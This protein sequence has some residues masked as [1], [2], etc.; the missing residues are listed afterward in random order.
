[1][2]CMKKGFPEENDLV[3]CSVT[4]V[5]RNCVF[6]N[7]DEYGKQGMIH[8]S[9]VSPGR[10]RNIRDFVREGR[11]IVCKVLRINEE[12]SH[13]DLSLRRVNDS[14]KRQKMNEI[15]L[16]QKAEKILE[17]AAKKFNIELNEL[18]GKIMSHISSK[19]ESLN[20]YFEDIALRGAS[21]DIALDDKVKK[22]IVDMIKQKIKLVEVDVEGNLSLKSYAPDGIE[23]IKKSLKKAQDAGK[24]SI[25]VAYKG[26]GLYFMVVRSS[27]Y[28]KAEKLINNASEAA[29]S[30]IE[31]NKGTGSFER[32]QQ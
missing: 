9:E 30:F 14:Q 13:I 16:E 10:I 23:V 11:K 26:A 29:I 2:L 24:G 6:A 4:S 15:K 28:K 32:V 21:I 19:Y 17:L 1:M 18:Y 5:Q 7:I 12:R 27:D 3:L 22:E 31:K 25:S 20:S 8:I